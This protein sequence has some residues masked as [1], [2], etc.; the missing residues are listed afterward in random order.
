MWRAVNWL[1]TNASGIQSAVVF[2]DSQSLCMAIESLTRVC[3]PPRGDQ[4]PLWTTNLFTQ[5]I[6]SHCNIPGD[7]LADAKVTRTDAAPR[8]PNEVTV[9]TPTWIKFLAI[10][11][12]IRTIPPPLSLLLDTSAVVFNC[13]TMSLY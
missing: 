1:V 8:T 3:P 10:Y 7:D 4:Q 6:P 9:S 11:A 13:F 12:R 2:T 5:W